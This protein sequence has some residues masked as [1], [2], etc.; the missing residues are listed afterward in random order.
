MT[1]SKRVLLVGLAA[2]AVALGASATSASAADFTIKFGY[3]TTPVHP[4]GLTLT[5]FKRI[6]ERESNGRVEVQLLASYAGA[7][8]IALLNDIKGG[9]V[10]GGAVSAAIWPAANIKSF[11]ALQMP[12]LI[13][14]YQLEQRVINNSSGIARDMLRKGTERAGLTGLGFLEGGMRQLFLKDPITSLRQLKGKKVRSV[15]S[16][17]LKDAL[18]ALGTEPVPLPL[19]DVFNSLK[20]GVV[21]GLEANS[22]LTFAQRFDEAGATNAVIANLFPFPAVVV[23]GNAAFRKLPRDLQTVVQNAARDLPAF[24]ISTLNDT[25]LFPGRLCTRGV[26]YQNLTTAGKRQLLRLTQPVYTK[27]QKDP[28]TANF[29]SRIQKIKAT[30]RNTTPTDV[31]PAGCLLPSTVGA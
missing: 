23:M 18:A 30:V 19:G 13:D 29:I 2:G 5:Q 15:E 8:D 11:I 20:T 22:A 26:R 12:G 1:R 31:P 9:S 14:S 24:S 16:P 4:Y 6:V 17:H 27:Y 3:V 21:D 7:N 28:Q 25:S 10:D